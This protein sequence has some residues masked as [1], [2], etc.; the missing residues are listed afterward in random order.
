[1]QLLRHTDV[2]RLHRR[3]DRLLVELTDGERL[4][5]LPLLV[6]REAALSISRTAGNLSLTED[7]AIFDLR[8]PLIVVLQ[9]L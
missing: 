5:G 3:A 6:D 8:E 7:S 4:A 1:L 2:A 9:F